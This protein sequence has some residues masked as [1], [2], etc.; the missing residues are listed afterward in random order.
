MSDELKPCVFCGRLNWRLWENPST[1]AQQI[2]CVS[3]GARGPLT[4][5]HRDPA[6]AAWNRRVPAKGEG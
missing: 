5:P 4:V 1:M 2:E 3:C 6:I